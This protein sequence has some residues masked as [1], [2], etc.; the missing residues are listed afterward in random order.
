[1]K[2]ISA[3]KR[4]LILS[5][6]MLNVIRILAVPIVI[7]SFIQTMYN[8]TDTYWIS[9]LGNDEMA[10][11]TVVTPVQNIILNFGSGITTAGSVLISH[12]LGA[13][14]DREANIMARHIY[15]CSMIFAFVCALLCFL[16]TPAVV[17]WLGAKGDVASFGITYLRIVILDM[18]LLYTINMYQSVHQSEGD[19]VSPMLLNLLGMGINLILDPV[20][21]ILF[22]MGVKGAAVATFAAKIPGAAIALYSL[23]KGGGLITIHYRDFSWDKEKFK[24][25][26]KIGLPTAIGGSTMQLGFLLMSRNVLEYGSVATAAYGIGNKVN[27]LI[28]LP[29][30]GIGS[31]VSIIV[32][33]NLGAGQKD[34]AEKGFRMSMWISVVFLFICGRILSIPEVARPIVRIF[35]KDE[36]TIYHAVNFLCLMAAWCF[37]NGVYN[38]AI[39]LFRGAGHTM[40]TMTVDAS[41]LWV[42][43]VLT[44]FICADVL[45]MGVESVWWSVVLSNAAT[46]VI[47][48][49]LYRMGMWEK[50]AVRVKGDRR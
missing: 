43:R 28:T 45:G 11:I 46:A 49:V 35:S 27:S 24:K 42:F 1:M 32:G 12:Y 39:A 13:K 31:A 47:I 14:K 5:G 26:I 3:E 36:E 16:A 40:V 7:N 41:R 21:I 20:L 19:T 23:T 50:D 44:L 22:S 34:R 48:Y 9:N 17:K 2:K 33:Q 30:N 29:C 4:E 18:P 25:I 6:N 37:T 15:L 8:L 10:S 38:P